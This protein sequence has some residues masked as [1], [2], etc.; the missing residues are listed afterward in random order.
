MA[1]ML[2]CLRLG[3]RMNAA[4]Q[5]EFPASVDRARMLFAALR[6][7]RTT[8]AFDSLLSGAVDPE[9]TTP[10]TGAIVAPAAIPP[11]VLPEPEIILP[12]GL[13]T[14]P[15]RHQLAAYRFCLDKFAA[16]KHGILLA[17]GMGCIEGD[18]ELVI[19]RQGCAKRMTMREFHRK[20]HGGESNGRR[21]QDFPTRTRSLIDG[22]FRLNEVQDVVAQGIK[23]VVRVAL[24]SG[25]SL[26]VTRDHEFAR[27]GDIW[28]E[29]GCLAVGD[30]VLTN[31]LPACK[32]CGGTHRVTT[33]RYA[34]HVGICRSCIGRLRGVKGKVIDKDG[35][36]RLYGME[37]HPRANKAGQVYEHIVVMERAMGR[38]IPA[39]EHVHHKNQIRHDN[40]PENLEVLPAAEHQSHHGRCGGY[41]HL[42]SERVQIVPRPDVVVSV[43]PDGETDVY[44]LK[45]AD[46]GHNFVA[47]GIV[48]H[49]C[50]KSL[51]ACMLL[52][53]LC[54]RRSKDK[55]APHVIVYCPL[56]VIQ[57]WLDQ[58]VKHVGIE[59]VVV[60][61]DDEAGTVAEKT[62]LAEEKMRLADVLCLPYICVVNYESAWREPF[63]VWTEKRAWDFI[64]AD[65]AHRIKSPSGKA[66]LEFKRLRT[67]AAYRVALTGTPMPHGPLDIFAIFRFLDITIFG[68]SFTA[69]RARYAVMGGYQ[70]RQ[71]V[72]YQNE[73]DLK[74]Q[75]ARITFRVGPEVLDLPPATEVTY[76]CAL[77]GEC[78]RI[79]KELDEDFVARVKDGTVTAANAMV[80]LL[81]LQQVT[82]GCVPTDD[83]TGQRVD[84]SKLKLLADT[85]EDI[86]PDEPVVVFCR[87]HADLNAVHEACQTHGYSAMELSGRRDDLR[88]WQN[89]EAQ[90]LAVQIDSGSEGVD[91]TRARYSIFY[92]IGYRLDK[93][94]QAKKRTHRPGQ[95]KPVTHIHLVARNT[96]DAKV[97]RA[98][99][100]RADII[101]SILADIKH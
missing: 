97:M 12:P 65:E 53:A 20:F 51:V 39:S 70:R 34:K 73:D 32:S 22:V 42:D 52:L 62:K 61:L 71:I 89:G 69:F 86:G 45:M 2:A 35:Y 23:P 8:P 28:T 16:G 74:T 55:K 67:R 21:W 19:N 4:G 100:K 95:E 66:S 38:P 54:E 11:V 99:E 64:I 94:E 56:R 9:S 81:R 91:L 75:M 58:F 47:N 88:R 30:T 82:G 60:P 80:K 68:P 98:L 43:E 14:A 50:G 37:H 36:V 101:E 1:D 29:A 3:G 5:F 77:A 18:A 48:V 13:L 92:S 57:V 63:A 24:A 83:G 76:Y 85:L 59:M 44:D 15:W 79:Y 31:G 93:Y 17:M 7:A 26:R 46:P 72:G 78:A 41:L 25:R 33:Y 49:N 87:F 40:R 96:V 27:P 84:S 6:G 90:V 10:T